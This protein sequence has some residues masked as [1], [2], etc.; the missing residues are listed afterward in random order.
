M[1]KRMSKHF[2]KDERLVNAMYAKLVEYIIREYKEMETFSKR[3]Y[4]E[5]VYPS[6]GEVQTILLEKKGN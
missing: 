4:R 5:D 3:V 2:C 1:M 6:R